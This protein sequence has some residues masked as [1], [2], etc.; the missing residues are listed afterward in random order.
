MLSNL[1]VVRKE[2]LGPPQKLVRP[3]ARVATMDM[4][5]SDSPQRHLF[6]NQ[7]SPTQ[8]NTNYNDIKKREKLQTVSSEKMKPAN[9]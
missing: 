7:P 4:A 6:S 3:K 8:R 2:I 9:N 1:E 5:A